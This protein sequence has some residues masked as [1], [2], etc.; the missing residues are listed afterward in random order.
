MATG[1]VLLV[2]SAVLLVSLE[3]F[4]TDR[5]VSSPLQPAATS[6][7]ANTGEALPVKVLSS[8]HERAFDLGGAVKIE[9]IL[10]PAGL[11]MMGE[12]GTTAWESP[13]HEV[14]ITKPFWIGKY[15]VTQEQWQA[16]MGSN[17]SHFK[18]PR[19][20]V[21]NVSWDNCHAF[22]KKLNEKFGNSGVKF[23][24]PTEAQWEYACRAGS[25][26]RYSFGEDES[27]LQD[28]AWI[29][30][31][32]EQATHPVGQK[33]PNAWGLYDMYGN[34]LELC[35]DWLGPAYYAESPID[36][37]PGP[38]TGTLPVVRGGAFTSEKAALECRSA[39]RVGCPSA[40]TRAMWMG[41]R[42]VVSDVPG[43]SVGGP[44]SAA[45]P[46]KWITPPPKPLPAQVAKPA[47]PASMRCAVQIA[48][49]QQ[50]RK[51]HG[52]AATEGRASSWYPSTVL[53][54]LVN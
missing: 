40:A 45:A 16:I 37:P 23:S 46:I 2:V 21:E 41:F 6:P 4:Q 43:H 35:A 42:V 31:N 28:Y 1:G 36:D 32:S 18:G 24:L 39:G 3:R 54:T 7:T 10:V 19:N 47:L 48:M 29:P 50:M 34:V 26:T 49:I 44:A 14:K 8:D 25:T 53:H 17:P 13:V 15:E 30:D 11:F 20:P 33:R 5:K 51:E 52:H 22:L 12:E 38:A 9:F 27:S